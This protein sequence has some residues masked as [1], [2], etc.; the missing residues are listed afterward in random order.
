MGTIVLGLLEIHCNSRSG[1][2]GDCVAESF[3]FFRELEIIVSSTFKT[4]TT[5]LR[6]LE[7][8]YNDQFSGAYIAL[9]FTQQTSAF[10]SEQYWI[11]NNN[12]RA[13]LL[14]NRHYIV[15]AKRYAQ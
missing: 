1:K 13:F 15:G 5:V 10:P 3:K 4:I 6:E 9:D 14:D 12:I 2:S 8:R 7:N 11:C